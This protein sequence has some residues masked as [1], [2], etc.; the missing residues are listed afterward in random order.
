MNYTNVTFQDILEELKNKIKSDGRFQ[1]FSD[2]DIAS[3]LMELMAGTIDYA[4]YNIERAVEEQFYSTGKRYRGHIK[5]ANNQGYDIKRPIPATATI[6]IEVSKDRGFPQDIQ[7][8]DEITLDI[9]QFTDF[10]FNGLKYVIQNHVNVIL[11]SEALIKLQNGEKIIVDGTPEYETYIN[12]DIESTVTKTK[13]LTLMQ[14]EFRVIKLIHEEVERDLNNEVHFPKFQKYLIE[15]PTF[16]NLYGEYDYQDGETT[17]VAIGVNESDAFSGDN[18]YE[19]ERRTLLKG[20][21]LNKIYMPDAD[22]N[23]PAK[24]VLVRTSAESFDGYGVE[25]R[26]GDGVTTSIG[27]DSNDYSVFVKYLSTSG[28]EANQT[29]VI[30]DTVSIT[31]KNNVIQK[32]YLKLK[33]IFTSNIVGGGDI[34]TLDSIAVNAPGVYQTFDRLITKKDYVDFMKSFTAPILVKNAL[35]WGE[36]EELKNISYLVDSDDISF[37]AIK[38]LNNTILFS[39]L[40]DLYEQA[41]GVY[42]IRKDLDS[43]VLDGRYSNY[44]IPGQSYINIFASDSVV[45]QL[46]FQQMNWDGTV[47]TRVSFVNKTAN[48]EIMRQ[49]SYE[50]LNYVAS[51]NVKMEIELTKNDGSSKTIK[52]EEEIFDGL[53]ANNSGW[54]TIIELLED[55][56]N[57]QLGVYLSYSNF[58]YVQ[59]SSN[60]ENDIKY[61]DN[62][63]EDPSTFNSPL[64][65]LKLEGNYTNNYNPLYQFDDIKIKYEIDWDENTIDEVKND[66]GTDPFRFEDMTTFKTTEQNIFPGFVTSDKINQFVSYLKNRSMVTEQ[67]IYVSPI[68]HDFAI[69]GKV[70]IKNLVNKSEIEKKINNAVYEFLSN[71]NDFNRDLYLSNI[72][73]IIESFDEVINANIRLAPIDLVKKIKGQ[74]S[75]LDWERLVGKDHYIYSYISKGHHSDSDLFLNSF[76]EVLIDFFNKYSII[77]PESTAEYLET[78][79]TKTLFK[80]WEL[81]NNTSEFEVL[82]KSTKLSDK[83]T[84]RS[85]MFE[86][87]KPL[88]DKIK[89]IYCL[90]DSARGYTPLIRTPEFYMFLAD[91]HN[92]MKEIIKLNMIN[93]NGDIAS[94]YHDELVDGIIVKVRDH[95][96]Y[97]INNE[98]A[99]IK[100][101]AIV[102]YK[103]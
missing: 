32:D 4:N 59:L 78:N 86:L 73:E 83:I 8:G 100:F 22:N 102:G 6:K 7:P 29:G 93:S 37:N 34:E 26:F 46:K 19:I 13:P 16:S 48:S 77:S 12:D 81:F 31:N 56:I 88:I 42:T 53:D 70:N 18:I 14:G 21:N 15:D 43:E 10:S 50:F 47:P 11:D 58:I 28:S 84:E 72:I 94:S 95:G 64:Y 62:N 38:K 97:T 75:H 96:G 79:E 41:D 57:S 33:A 5:L 55:R 90:S 68:I 87:V 103:D 65:E 30:G 24:I 1:N 20:N 60:L 92:D 27:I 67:T 9:P 51:Q 69:I 54:K 99:R 76:E 85:F 82:Q 91:V 66:I 101:D 52:W 45:A 63:G 80:G 25:L 49:G 61:W 3:V 39:V 36:Q 17:V 89:N 2:S 35:A 74:S 23:E 98:I 40:G 44:Q 71:K